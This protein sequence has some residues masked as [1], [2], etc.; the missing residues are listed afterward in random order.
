MAD[1]V[2]VQVKGLKEL[3]DALKQMPEKLAGQ[4]LGASVKAGADL[5][6]NQ[7]QANARA[8]FKDASGATEKSIVSYRKKGSTQT[9][10]TY[11]VGVT[12]QKR[13]PRPGG[14][15]LPAYWWRFKEFGTRKM[16]ATPFLRPAWDGRSGEA[17]AMIKRM[18]EKAVEVAATQVPRFNG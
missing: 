13:W 3:A 1:S 6:K 5:I 18:L 17:L 12:L 8:A 2:E 14:K 16:P 11:Q 10:I 4:A 15:K 7:A 9:D